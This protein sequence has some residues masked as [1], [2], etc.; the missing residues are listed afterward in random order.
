MCVA[1]LSGYLSDR[2][3]SRFIST[4]GAFIMAVGLFMLGLMNAATPVP[5]ILVS[6]AVTGLGFGIFQTPN[7]SAIMNN[8]PASSRGVASGMLAT[9]RNMGMVI[10]VGLSGALFSVFSG[11][12]G[13]AG[14]EALTGIAIDKA[15][16]SQGLHMTFVVA[17]IVALGAMAASLTKGKAKPVGVRKDVH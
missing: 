12:A 3:D 10:G 8:A 7:N 2:V 11:L 15:S 9:A 6:M 4:A 13:S 17:S 5:Y 14:P 16:F 1:P